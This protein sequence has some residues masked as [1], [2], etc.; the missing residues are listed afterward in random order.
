MFDAGHRSFFPPAKNCT[1]WR[2]LDFAKFRSLLETKTLYFTR[3]DR[4]EDPW[5]GMP[6]PEFVRRFRA[7]NKGAPADRLEGLVQVFCK[8]RETFFVSCWCASEHESAA[9]WKLYPEGVA[10]LT[11]HDRL[12][13]VFEASPPKYERPASS[14]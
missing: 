8:M 14:T 10:I 1:L 5:E 12:S 13:K 6:S 11:D 4:F 9:M 7:Q 3:D 2:Y